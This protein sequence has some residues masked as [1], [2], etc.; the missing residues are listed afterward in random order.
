MNSFIHP[1][2]QPKEEHKTDYRKVII[3][4]IIV[5][6]MG[7]AA[8]AYLTY[9]G[10]FK[11]VTDLVCG[12]VNFTAPPQTCTP[13]IS[14]P[15]CPDCNCAVCPDINPTFKLYLNATA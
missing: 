8:F 6:L 10:Y 9:N 1:L 7:V 3:F 4:L 5:I 13:T 15:Q 11:N 2:S 14:I 12:S